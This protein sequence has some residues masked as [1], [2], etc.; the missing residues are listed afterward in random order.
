MTAMPGDE[1]NAWECNLSL[2]GNETTRTIRPRQGV[3][4]L[5]PV[6]MNAVEVGYSYAHC[7]RDKR[8][9]VRGVTIALWYFICR[10]HQAIALLPYCFKNYA[11]K[12]SRYSEL[13]MLYR[14]NLIE[15]TPGYGSEKY[16]EVNRI[17]VNRAYET[18]GCIVARSQMQG[19]TERKANLV[20]VVEQRLLMPTFNGDDIMF[21]ID[22]PL[23]RNG[24]TLKQTLECEQNSPDWRACSEHQLLYSDQKHWMEKLSLLVP[25][26]SSWAKM[27]ALMQNPVA[28]TRTHFDDYFGQESH[29]TIPIMSSP[30]SNMIDCISR[31]HR[32]PSDIALE[33]S[34]TPSS[35]M[36]M[37]RNSIHDRRLSTTRSRRRESTHNSNVTTSSVASTNSTQSCGS[38][39]HAAECS[40]YRTVPRTRESPFSII[41]RLFQ[42]F[43]TRGSDEEDPIDQ[44]S[45]EIP[46]EIIEQLRLDEEWRKKEME[47]LRADETLAKL[48]QI[49]GYSKSSRVMAK[50]ENI[51]NFG[52]LV[53]KCL[54][55]EDQE[56]DSI[57]FDDVYQGSPNNAA[58]SSNDD[59]IDFSEDMPNP[60]ADIDCFAPVEP[61]N[62]VS[63]DLLL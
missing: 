32:Q 33:V 12:S 6:F 18:G 45:D 63:V 2:V 49:F 43:T 54:L 11:E 55:E 44:G 21:P 14:L 26:K 24:P 47:R 36:S 46:D 22:G 53:E 15:F 31:H 13:M 52:Q 50:F 7:D 29:S 51:R 38:L 1:A 61:S 59:L 37:S 62:N 58:S 39:G 34:D 5:R 28:S 27:T 16:T 8:L 17:M 56:G 40:C 20:N 9:N 41:V 25:E 19:I 10:G 3:T 4:L 60:P 48:S 57:E 35:S 42:S 30:A 23:G